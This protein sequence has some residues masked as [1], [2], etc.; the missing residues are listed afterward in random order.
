MF[1]SRD[2]ENVYQMKLG[3]EKGSVIAEKDPGLERVPGHQQESGEVS[4]R[5]NGLVWD[6]LNVMS[7][8]YLRRA[9]P[10]LLEI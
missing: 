10:R 5:D 4:R 6:M 3:D 7:A 2:K 9:P 1:A 8:G